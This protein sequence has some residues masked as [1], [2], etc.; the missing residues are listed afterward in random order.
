MLLAALDVRR[1][2]RDVDFQGRHV[3]N[4]VDQILA[5]VKTIASTRLDDGL[6]LH[7]DAATAEIIRNA[8]LAWVPTRVLLSA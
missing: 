6:V 8:R 5:I 2:T 3:S 4:D 1:P 7:P